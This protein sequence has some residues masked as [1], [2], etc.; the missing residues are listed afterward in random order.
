MTICIAAL[1][2]VG[3]AWAVM[4]TCYLVLESVKSFMPRLAQKCQIDFTPAQGS[5]GQDVQAEGR[6][7]GIK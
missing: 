3:F 4:H 5:P 6:L 1:G 7:T 2:F